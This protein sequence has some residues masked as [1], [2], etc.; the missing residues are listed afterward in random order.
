MSAF[1]RVLSILLV[2]ALAA[3]GQP[4]SHDWNNV[5]IMT[6]GTEVK[7]N[8]ASRTLRGQIQGV[9]DDALTIY[10]GRGTQVVMRS[11]IIRVSI[12]K[13]GHRGRNALIGLAAGAGAGAA[14]G[15]ATAESC[16]DFC[17]LSTGSG[18]AAGAAVFG[19]IGTLIG[20][21]IPTGGW[22]EIYAQ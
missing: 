13:K 3:A 11:E 5:K 19:V 14:I 15:A 16:S 4:P 2:F 22:R 17:I 12:K 7:I 8:V 20:T 10:S 6:T 1:I 18:A 9:T 21:V